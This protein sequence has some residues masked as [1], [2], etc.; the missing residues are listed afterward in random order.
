M[1]RGPRNSEAGAGEWGVSAPPA[2][3]CE[4]DGTERSRQRRRERS[5]FRWACIYRRLGMMVS[6]ISSDLMAW[7]KLHYTTLRE[8]RSR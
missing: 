8:I 4:T 5:M 3:G 2:G 6:G 1:S 7:V